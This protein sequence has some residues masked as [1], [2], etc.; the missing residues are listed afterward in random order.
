MAKYV[1]ISKYDELDEMLEEYVN[2]QGCY[3]W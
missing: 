3:S 2:K 1:D